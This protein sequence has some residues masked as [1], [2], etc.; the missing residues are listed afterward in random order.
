[1]IDYVLRFYQQND[2]HQDVI[3]QTQQEILQHYQPI[4]NYKEYFTLKNRML[5]YASYGIRVDIDYHPDNIYRVVA[6]TYNRTDQQAQNELHRVLAVVD[7]LRRRQN[8][9][10]DHETEIEDGIISY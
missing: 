10:I 1:M 8:M 7:T 9:I 6:R 3:L 2:L 4:I 5:T